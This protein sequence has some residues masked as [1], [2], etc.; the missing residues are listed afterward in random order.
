M[1]FRPS[2]VYDVTY[3]QD[4]AIYR[5]RVDWFCRLLDSSD[6]YCSFNIPVQV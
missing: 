4:T 6:L 1:S 2:G 5:T 3:E